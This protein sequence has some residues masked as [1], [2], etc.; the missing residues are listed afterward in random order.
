MKLCVTFASVRFKDGMEWFLGRH[1]MQG[2]A[3]ILEETNGVKKEE[4]EDDG[5]PSAYQ[6]VAQIIMSKQVTRQSAVCPRNMNTGMSGGGINQQFVSRQ[7][8]RSMVSLSALVRKAHLYE[9]L[10]RFSSAV[11]A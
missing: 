11:D 2:R 8:V 9:L 7:M 3:S 4:T 6:R 10:N 1:Q 5:E